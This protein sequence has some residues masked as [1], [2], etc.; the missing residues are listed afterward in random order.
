MKVTTVGG[1]PGGLYAAIL[2]KT[3]DPSRQITVLE[4][5]APDDT[6]GWGVVFSRATLAELEA[7][8]EPTYTA[9]MRA[10]ATWDPV[11]IHFKG[12]VV[13]A[14]GNRFAAISRKTLLAILQSRCA[15]LG[16]EVQYKCEVQDVDSL[17]GCDLLIAAD[18]A[19]SLVR[20]R[21]AE[22]FKP[23]FT[24]EGGKF[25]WLGTTRPM[26][27]FTFVFAQTDAGQ[28]QAHAYPF[29]ETHST[30]IVEVDQRTWTR[31]GVGEWAASGLAPG[32]SDMRS[33][34][35]CEELFSEYLAGHP[36]LPN[37]SKWLDWRTIKNASWHHGNVVLLGDAA[38]TAH[39]SIGS[40]TKLAMEDAIAL[41]D[42]LGSGSCLDEALGSYEA[43]RKVAV[44]MV[45]DAARE[46]LD[47]FDRYARY[48]AFDPPQFAYSLLTRSKRVT[49]DSLRRRD[50]RFLTGFEQWFAERDD[51]P[52][53]AARLSAPQPWQSPL[54]L[55]PTSLHNRIALTVSATELPAREGVVEAA[56]CQVAADLAGTGAALVVLQGVA[57]QAAGRI[58]P[59]SPGLYEPRHAEAWSAYVQNARSL[60]GAAVGIQLMHAGARASMRPAREGADVPLHRGWPTLAASARAYTP[61]GP[62]PSQIGPAG[63]EAAVSAF[64]WAAQEAAT[65][66]FDI[67]ELHLAHGY[68]L[69]GFLSPLTNERDDEYG[70]S[71]ENRARFPMEVVEAVRAVWPRDRLLSVTL[72][73]SDLQRGGSGLAEAVTVASW[74]RERGVDVAS[75]VAGQTTPLA[76]AAYETAFYAPFCDAVRNEAGLAT[77]AS[78]NIGSLDDA[79]HVIAAGKADICVLGRPRDA[80]PDWLERWR[81][82]GRQFSPS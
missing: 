68:L 18:G 65:C 35:F 73:G 4:R 16:I 30:F 23:K 28:W 5:N 41:A 78:G 56:A 14:G 48:A 80:E 17:L 74:L 79:N 12:E 43:D 61:G 19:N 53:A 52:H 39:F 15:E 55:G 67:I 58:S 33:I 81:R 6:F 57:V 50:R 44:E 51:G 38:H 46:S 59:E 64:V 22:Q 26:D 69:A 34:E 76:R 1:G 9:L 7:A 77:I 49:F 37:N 45:Q 3:A 66:G 36:L 24:P 42:A 40:G 70:G 13:R 75:V 25:I 63:M 71:L 31:A 27:A 60:A 8:D 54:T 47:W 21:F 72:S 62:V 11:E 82:R 20:G 32:E 2:L 10:S 29:S